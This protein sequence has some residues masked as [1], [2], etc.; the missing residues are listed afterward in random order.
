MTLDEINSIFSTAEITLF[1]GAKFYTFYTF[2]KPDGTG[3][4]S[5]VVDP[6]NLHELE[7]MLEG[8]DFREY[9]PGQV[10]VFVK[11]AVIEGK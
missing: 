5:S 6:R 9:A 10:P 4:G 2:E 7:T 3:R 11:R 1:G 8:Y